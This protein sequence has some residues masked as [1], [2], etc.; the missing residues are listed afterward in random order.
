MFARIPATVLIALLSLALPSTTLALGNGVWVD[1]RH[2]AFSCTDDFSEVSQVWQAMGASVHITTEL[3]Y[4]QLTSG[5][6]RLLVIMLPNPG[7]E[8]NCQQ[9]GAYN[10]PFCNQEIE[11]LF[12]YF[13]LLGGRIV[14]LA[15]NATEAPAN[16]GIR[17]ILSSLT[18]DMQLNEDNLSSSCSATSQIVGDPLTAGLSQW[19]FQQVN[20]ISGGDALIRFSIGA[21]VHTLAAVSRPS[22]GGEIIVFGDSD[23]FTGSCPNAANQTALWQNLYSDQSAAVDGDG[24]GYESDEDCNDADPYVNP[25]ADE[26]CDN[27]IDDDC[28]EAIDGSD[29]DCGGSDDD[30]HAGGDDTGGGGDDTGGGGDDNNDDFGDDDASTENPV[31]AEDRWQTGCCQPMTYADDLTG[32]QASFLLLVLGAGIRRTRRS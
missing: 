3:D 27:L 15:D 30:S 19:N 14:L 20:T 12:P 31:E 2:G 9:Y 16:N 21:S 28:D 23:G 18:P 13:L 8:A 17:Q 5:D 10:S 7:T 24:D 29:Q 25:G 1:C 6:Y 11:M 4:N 26:D 22:D 32:L